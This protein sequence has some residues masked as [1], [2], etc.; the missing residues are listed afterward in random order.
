MRYLGG[1]TF[2]MYQLSGCR[3]EKKKNQGC[4]WED[5]ALEARECRCLQVPRKDKRDIW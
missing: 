4:M 1:K 3:D 5:M 2:R